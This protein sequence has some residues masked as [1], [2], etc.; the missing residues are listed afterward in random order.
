MQ[1]TQI[2]K[3]KKIKATKNNKNIIYNDNQCLYFN[4]SADSHLG[5]K[6]QDD[7]VAFKVG[8]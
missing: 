7:I 2:E 3:N 8:W 6:I 5:D 4:I 1:N